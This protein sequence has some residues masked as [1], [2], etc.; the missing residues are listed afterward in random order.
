MKELNKAVQDL[1][2]EGETIKKTQIEAT[3]EME[4]LGKRSET[5]DAS[6]NHRIQEIEE[7]ISGVDDTLEDTDTMVKENSKHKKL[8]T[9]KGT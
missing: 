6:I 3:L 2:I 4:N 1:K 8:L 9:T 7:K 5:T